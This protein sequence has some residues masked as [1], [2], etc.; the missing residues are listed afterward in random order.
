MRMF[1]DGVSGRQML[2]DHGVPNGGAEE[3]GLPNLLEGRPEYDS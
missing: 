3:R 1:E 2:D